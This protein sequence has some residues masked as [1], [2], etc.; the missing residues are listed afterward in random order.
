MNLTKEQRAAI[1]CPD[2]VVLVSA[3]PGSGKTRTLVEKVYSWVCVSTDPVTC[4]T[5]TRKATAEMRQR[6]EGR[7][8]SPVTIDTFHG[9]CLGIVRSCAEALGWRHGVNPIDQD[10]AKQVWNDCCLYLDI[11]SGFSWDNYG[12]YLAGRWEPRDV[13]VLKRIEAEYHRRLRDSNYMDFETIILKATEAIHK[14]LY[15]IAG[16]L[17]VDEAQDTDARQYQFLKYVLQAGQLKQLFIVGD[18]NQSIYAWRGARPELFNALDAYLEKPVTHFR[19]SLNFRS[20]PEICR[21][22]DLFAGEPME[23]ACTEYMDNLI[24]IQGYGDDIQEAADI[25][26][27]CNLPKGE[28]L[29]ILYRNHS[30]GMKIAESL[31]V[32]DIPFQ[33]VGEAGEDFWKRPDV[34]DAVAYMR[35]IENPYNEQDFRRWFIY[36][37]CEHG[38]EFVIGHAREHGFTPYQS[39]VKLSM[40]GITHTIPDDLNEIVNSFPDTRAFLDWYAMR[41]I[42]PEADTSEAQITLSTVHAAKGREWDHVIIAGVDATVWPGRGNYDEER[43]LLY[44]AI[45]RARKSVLITY[46]E[47]RDRGWGM[48]PTGPSPFIETILKGG[49]NPDEV[50]RQEDRET[51][52]SIA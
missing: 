39:L 1:Q 45:T 26:D 6:L 23:S 35:M 14:G 7:V 11:K 19:L 41:Q 40:N 42:E 31:K 49:S 36:Q 37:S 47:Q 16:L 28:T 21:T 25:P 13:R 48:K 17:C 2:P 46:A 12:R 3:C 27:Y 4:I 20:G 51:I 44:V 24:G 10:E 29:G 30:I 18:V 50:N 5:F 33:R 43:R 22:A 52:Q 32:A 38:A 8:E 15:T 9:L 34:A